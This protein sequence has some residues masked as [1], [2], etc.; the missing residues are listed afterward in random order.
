M[1]YVFRCRLLETGG[2][3]SSQGALKRRGTAK[4]TRSKARYVMYTYVVFDS[5]DQGY[6]DMYI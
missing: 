5:L 1:Y 6:I 3:K 4:P 2:E